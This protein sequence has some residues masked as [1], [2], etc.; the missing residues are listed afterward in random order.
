MEASASMLGLDGD[1]LRQAR[2]E[3]LLYAASAPLV[4]GKNPKIVEEE[5]YPN[6]YRSGT[7]NT[8]LPIFSSQFVLPVG[9][10]R[11]CDDNR[12]EEMVIP[13]P[14]PS[15]AADTQKLVSI[16]SLDD[17]AK[18]AFKGYSNLNRVQSLVYPVAYGTNENMLV[19]APT[20]AVKKGESFVSVPLSGLQHLT[21][22]FSSFKGKTDVAMLTVMRALS[23]FIVTG[24]DGRSRLAKDDFKIVYVAPMKALAAEVV[25]KFGSRLGGSFEKG[26]GIGISVRELTGDMQ[27]TKTEI[28][29]TQMIVTT[30]EKWDVVTRKGV[31][32]TELTQ[33]V[34]LL[35]IDE[36]HLLNEDRG[37][38][39]E[40]I[41]ART[42]RQVETSQSMIRIVGL[43][44]TLPNFVDVAKFL[45][46]NLYQG[47]FYFDSSFRPVPL[48]QHF[49]GVK[50]KPGSSTSQSYMNQVCY[51]KVVDLV[52]Q[53]HQVMVFV[54]ARKETVKTASYLRDEAGMANSLGV[55]DCTND[56]Q[57][58]FAAKE[59]SRSRNNELKS[60]F[61][62]G[63]GIHHAVKKKGGGK[64][65][66]FTSSEI[67][68][69]LSFLGYAS[70]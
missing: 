18:R 3:Q 66:V 29:S 55:F 69:L 21:S 36:V 49:I 4:S 24:E 1:H 9:T 7:A 6:V 30:P 15:P 37:S 64:A 70:F 48:K 20:G 52:A 8:K 45:G 57:Y 63:F 31:G 28:S 33:K 10:E 54:H 42:L 40:S 61:S 58:G 39:I 12:F 35:I 41:V 38:V 34:R 47:M 23:Q 14:K 68:P 65:C 26:D 44:A 19:C 67:N 5:Q 56:P 53:G 2:E 60:L 27:L 43:S 11:Y 59:M 25:Q 46:V 16:S 50:G 32:D 62:N 13:Y 51:E 17:F 22:P